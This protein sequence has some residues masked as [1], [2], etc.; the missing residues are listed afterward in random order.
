MYQNFF[1]YFHCN[2][3]AP[4]CAHPQVRIITN[5]KV[6][7]ELEVGDKGWYWLEG[8]SGGGKHYNS[9]LINNIQNKLIKPKCSVKV[10]YW[11][12]KTAISYCLI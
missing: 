2:V 12:N 3:Y 10:N 5:E 1:L 8:E 9:I 7:Y 11:R 4:L 6:V